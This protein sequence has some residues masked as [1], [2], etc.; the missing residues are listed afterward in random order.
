MGIVIEELFPEVCNLFGDGGNMLYLKLCLPEAE[1]ISTALNS[2]PYFAGHDVNMIYMGPMTE[3]TQQLVIK[4]LTPYKQRIAEL[5][6]KGVIFLMT[7]NSHEIFG[8][9]I[10]D[11]DGTTVD[12]LGINDFHAERNM[13]KRFSGLVLGKY[14]D[15]EIAAFR[16]QFTEGFA[17]DGLSP[18][19]QMTKGVPMNKKTFTEGYV[20][21]NFYGTYLLGPL[22]VLNPYFTRKLICKLCGKERTL[23]FEPEVIRAYEARLADFKDKKVGIH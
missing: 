12:C 14:E 5:I 18:F 11:A 10:T 20:R 22:L 7:G 2:T 19:V 4:R 15:I 9:R 8:S 1:Y 21:N 3:N 23:A 13:M 16:A 6:E 17:G